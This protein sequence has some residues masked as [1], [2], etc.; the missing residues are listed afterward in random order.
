MEL[1]FSKI[2]R[3]LTSAIICLLFCTPITTVEKSVGEIFMLFPNCHVRLVSSKMELFP[4][5]SSHIISSTLYRNVT[6]STYIY[7]V[8]DFY[9]RLHPYQ[10]QSPYVAL[11]FMPTFL[12]VYMEDEFT[13]G[14]QEYFYFKHVVLRELS[15]IESPHHFLFVGG[16]SEY[17]TESRNRQMNFYLT[18][19]ETSAKGIILSINH[20]RNLSNYRIQL[21]CIICEET[22]KEIDLYG[23]SPKKLLQQL[24]PTT[25]SIFLHKQVKIREFA[26]VKAIVD[27]NCD[28]GN[29]KVHPKFPEKYPLFCLYYVLIS[30]YN[31]TLGA[32]TETRDK[33]RSN[34]YIDMHTYATIYSELYTSHRLRRRGKSI[35]SEPFR[36]FTLRFTMFQP[37]SAFSIAELARPFDW[38]SWLAA[39]ITL[40]AL[41]C[42]L[43]MQTLPTSGGFFEAIFSLVRIGV[44]QPSSEH[45]IRAGGIKSHI[46]LA[47]LVAMVVLSEAYKG[48]ILSFL[49]KPSEAFWPTGFREL[50]LD[51]SYM[52]MSFD[53]E[54]TFNYSNHPIYS[55]LLEIMFTSE[56]D[57]TT[58]FF[59]KDYFLLKHAVVQEIRKD[60]ISATADFLWASRYG[61]RGSTPTLFKMGNESS[62]KLA[63]LY[64]EYTES[65]LPLMAT[66][67]PDLSASNP[68]KLPAFSETV[69]WF[70]SNGFLLQWYANSMSRLA[71]TGFAQAIQN[72]WKTWNPCIYLRDVLLKLKTYQNVTP[73]NF[74]QEVSKCLRMS[75]SRRTS[76]VTNSVSQTHGHANALRITQFAGVFMLALFCLTVAF[77]F[78]MFEW[79]IHAVGKTEK[80]YLENLRNFLES[81]CHPTNVDVFDG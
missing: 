22:L 18:L 61:S 78:I 3:L 42:V 20:D 65:F 75:L 62:T 41:T 11:K 55:P 76:G 31:I 57:S 21:V 72:Y 36:T 56:A 80:N 30:A 58:K 49:T 46:L 8:N 73:G 43:S 2:S 51:A 29:A 59:G 34:I 71:A 69:G 7:G 81:H 64:L 48:K 53:T 52:L 15:T 5:R 32:V 1:K 47:W 24:Q 77:V 23:A 19:Y 25:H 68:V 40:I 16:F 63:Y 12:H 9:N 66:L 13:V 37:S 10:I 17:D 26:A 14:D 6:F 44:N 45:T 27:S 28:F 38:K 74:I 39:F 35:I 79:I 50:V 60:V 33:S 70:V 67:Y 54:D 4:G